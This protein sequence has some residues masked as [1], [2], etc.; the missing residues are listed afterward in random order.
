MSSPIEVI[1]NAGS[2]SVESAETKRRLEKL[3]KENN[4][5]ANVN[6]AKDGAEIVGLAKKA[7]ESGAEIIV[8]GGG[9]GTV[10]AV[11]SEIYKT[12]KTL[13]VLPFGTLNNFSKDLNIRAEPRR[14]R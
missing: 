7:V 2:G 13:G 11:A 10:S 4:L 6:L 14:S 8:A 1:I 12:D 3:F 5:D 9:D